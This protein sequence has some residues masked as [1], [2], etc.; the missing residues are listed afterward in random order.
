MSVI[1]AIK[2]GA[3]QRRTIIDVTRELGP[4][5]AQRAS[6]ATDEDQFVAENFALLKAS[7]LME[8]GVPAEL[9]GGGAD[10]DELAAVL[11]TLGYH[12]G[13]TGLALSMH[14]HLVATAAWRWKHQGQPPSSRC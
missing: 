9:G 6:E 13:S 10:V 5:I 11:Q 7:G 2:T 1:Q 3:A 12:C 8:A 14:T 4:I